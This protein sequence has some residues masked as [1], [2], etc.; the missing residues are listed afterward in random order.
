MKKNKLNDVWLLFL[1]KIRRLSPK[2]RAIDTFV[3][4]HL[5][6]SSHEAQTITNETYS[7]NSQEP[8]TYEEY[9]Q[10]HI[11]IMME[12]M[13]LSRDEAEKE[14]NGPPNKAFLMD[15]FQKSQSQTLT[16]NKQSSGGWLSDS[17]TCQ[18]KTR[19]AP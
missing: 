17:I 7:R 1:N 5:E 13:G 3:I 6:Y 14:V 2:E 15:E 18:A 10:K 16:K 9:E 4:K 8:K 12:K 11:E 19:P